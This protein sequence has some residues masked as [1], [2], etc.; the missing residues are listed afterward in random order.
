M[1]LQ[2]VIRDENF[3]NYSYVKEFEFSKGESTRFLIDKLT[4]ALFRTKE[5]LFK[6]DF[7]I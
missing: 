2:N 1:Y 7:N 4:D 3:E 6:N 5:L